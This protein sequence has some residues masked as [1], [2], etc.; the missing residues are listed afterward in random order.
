MVLTTS[1]TE[2][3]HAS[4]STLQARRSLEHHRI[5]PRGIWS[6]ANTWDCNCV[7]TAGDDNVVV[8]HEVSL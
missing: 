8:N 2:M 5:G 7:P 4:L 3:T 6:E 1:R